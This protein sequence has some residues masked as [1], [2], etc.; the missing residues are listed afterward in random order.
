MRIVWSS[1]LLIASCLLAAPVHAQIYRHVDEHGVVHFSD[2]PPDQDTFDVIDQADLD[3]ATTTIQ[4][5]PPPEARDQVRLEQERARRSS[6]QA[7]AAERRRAEQAAH[8][9]RCAGY[10]SRLEAIQA[11]LRAGYSVAEGNRLR[12]ERRDLRARHGRECHGL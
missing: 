3:A 1:I 6:V 4:S 8:E 11:R 5:A 10:E 2:E 9:A 7:Q 12:A